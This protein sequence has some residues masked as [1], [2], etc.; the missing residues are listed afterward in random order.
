MWLGCVFIW[1]VML[2]CIVG[3][4][5]RSS[6]CEGMYKLIK[7]RG[8]KGWFAMRV[9]WRNGDIFAGVGILERLQGNACCVLVVVVPLWI[10]YVIRWRVVLVMLCVLLKNSLYWGNKYFVDLVAVSLVSWMVMIDED[11]WGSVISSCRHGMA[12]FSEEA[13]H[14]IA[15]DSWL[16]SGGVSFDGGRFCVGGVRV[17]IFFY[18]FIIS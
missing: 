6:S 7:S 8:C 5:G 12:V 9:I 3:M 15:Y 14:V 11:C 10:L 4:R 16:V 18:G 17:G 13:F 2:V 1:W